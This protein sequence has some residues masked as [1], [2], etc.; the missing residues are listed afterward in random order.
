MVT[1]VKLDIGEVTQDKA[2]IITVNKAIGNFN[3]TSSF[4]IEFNNDSG[5]FDDTFALNDKVEIWAEKDVNPATTKIFTGVIEDI[6][7]EGNNQEENIKLTGRDVGA[8]LQ[9][10]IMQP[11]VWKDTEVSVIVGD[12]MNQNISAQ[13]I[14]TTNVNTTTT[15]LN[16]ITLQNISVFDALKK[17]AELSEFFFYVDVNND[18]HF[19][20]LNNT[21]SGLT[22]DNTNITRARFR[23]S[24]RD[25]FNKVIIYGDRILSGHEEFKVADGGSVFNLDYKPHNVNVSLSGVTNTLQQI[26]GVLN[27]NDPA[28]TSG[29][30]YLVD[31]QGQNIIMVSGTEAGD[32]IPTSGTDRFFINYER[33]SPIISLKTDIISQ[34]TYGLKDK[35]IVDRGIKD[36]EEASK[37]ATSFILDHK[38]ER[39]M[40]DLDI[41][42][43]IDVTPGE[44][45]IVNIP[46]HSINNQVYKILNA[47][48]LF[49]KKNNLG[50][51]V[52]RIS[53]NKR[54]SDFTDTMKDQ[55]LRMKNIEI[56]QIDAGVIILQT[57]LGSIG[58]SGPWRV[59]S[60]SIGSAFYFHVDNHNILNSDTSLLG[61]MRAGSIVESGGF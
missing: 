27:L 36:P 31:F 38:D 24:D 21:S 1:F 30:K 42:G 44:T 28:T 57:D 26:G 58:V 53:V 17:L 19:E 50:D 59:I 54:I 39:V 9:D 20:R 34:A 60:R 18:L 47:E 16:K 46:F 32:N 56:S 55:M 49:N 48:Y 41:N 33:N 13:L 22:F 6:K 11:R 8:I 12:I 35:V 43:I 45:C 5:R 2:E 52:L 23:R 7:Y 15:T 61:D 3:S 4:E 14:T 29:L 51:N 25:L 10:T 40:G 37:K